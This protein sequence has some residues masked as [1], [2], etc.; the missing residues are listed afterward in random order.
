MRWR[1]ACLRVRDTLYLDDALQL[2]HI[3]PLCFYQL[4]QDV[5]A[6]TEELPQSL[7]LV[8]AGVGC[9]AVFVHATTRTLP[10]SVGTALM[11]V[12]GF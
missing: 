10:V 8:G 7:T 9:E 6:Q 4:R 1:A 11:T 2:L 12:T 5:P 3:E